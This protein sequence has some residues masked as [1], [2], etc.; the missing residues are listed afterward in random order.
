M[1]EGSPPFG[2]RAVSGVDSIV[3]GATKLALFP[4]FR[5]ALLGSIL[6]RAAPAAK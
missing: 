6:V 5:F 1:V 3:I 2:Y 4:G